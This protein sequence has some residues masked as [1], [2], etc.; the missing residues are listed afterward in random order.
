MNK[1]ATTDR[2]IVNHTSTGT[3]GTIQ[4]SS[5]IS[6]RRFLGDGTSLLGAA[7]LAGTLPRSTFAVDTA[8]K[9]VRIGIVGG[10]FGLSFQW[11]L[12]PDCIVQAVSDLRPERRQRLMQTYKCDKA[13]NSLEE[14]VL[15]K[16]IDAIGLFTEGPNHVKHTRLAMKHGK[17]VISAVPAC[18]ATVDEAHELLDIVKQSGLTYMM[19]ETSYYQQKTISARKFYE[20][21]VFGEIHYCESDYPH[22]GLEALYYENGKRTWRH[23]VAPMHYPTHN[24]AHLIGITGERLTE[25]TCHGWGDD[26]PICKDNIYNNP[27]W[28]ET[29]TFRTNK[30]HPFVVRVWW[31][32]ASLHGVRA[33]WHGTKMSFRAPAMNTPHHNGLDNYWIISRSNQTTKDAGGFVVNL[34][35][36]GRYEQPKWYE[37]DMLP[38]PLRTL[39]DTGHEG[40]HAF[41]THEFIDALVHNRKPAVDVYEALA[42]TV[43]GIIAHESAL[44]GGERL[45]IPQFDPA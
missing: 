25:V 44:K 42:Y 5:Q 16:N 11:H 8:P 9:K 17:H 24:T 43:P 12:H 26:H 32:C 28:N 27:F 4:T 6:R 13:Y 1:K 7:A 19:A 29:A 2:Q 41:L 34:P 39:G 40:S 36:Y 31:R 33:E 23:G 10:S 38:E 3:E 18:W 15:D 22:D 20:E 30:G 37:T 14:M 45:T 35:H 21:G